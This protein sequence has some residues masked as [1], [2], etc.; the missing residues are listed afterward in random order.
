MTDIR[1]PSE[2]FLKSMALYLSLPIRAV[3]MS[4]NGVRQH[5]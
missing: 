4:E 5:V 2:A 3:E 1:V